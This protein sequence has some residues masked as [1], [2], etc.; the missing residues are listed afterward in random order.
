[1]DYSRD[2]SYFAHLCIRL[3]APAVC[4]VSF[5]FGV[6]AFTDCDASQSAD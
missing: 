4:V 6:F 5:E 1:M 3:I 2:I